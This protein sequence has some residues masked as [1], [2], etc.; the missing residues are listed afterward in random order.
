MF[1]TLWALCISWTSM[2]SDFAV[3]WISAFVACLLHHTA[4]ADV[5][6]GLLCQVVLDRVKAAE[7]LPG[8]GEILLPGE[9]GDRLAAQRRATGLVPLEPNLYQNLKVMASKADILSTGAGNGAGQPDSSNW[10]PATRLLHPAASSVVDPYKGSMPPLWQT[11]TYE[12]PGGT[13]GGPYDYTRSG[14]PTRTMLEEQ[15]HEGL[16]EVRWFA[17]CG[18]GH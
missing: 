9:R 11:A 17:A 15:V 2:G 14:N 13:V 10:R 16:V 3:P 6:V 12:Q 8:V 18:C 7:K 4:W 1:A 5:D